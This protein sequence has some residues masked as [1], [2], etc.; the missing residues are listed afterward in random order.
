MSTSIGSVGVE[1]EDVD[2]G[3]SPLVQRFGAVVVVEI[4]SVLLPP[5]E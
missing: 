1:L 5:E 4:A 2:S 3:G